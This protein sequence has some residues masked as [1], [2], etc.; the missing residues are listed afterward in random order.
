ML[1]NI[2]SKLSAQVGLTIIGTLLNAFSGGLA[3]SF[4]IPFFNLFSGESNHGGGYERIAQS[5]P[6]RNT[7]PIILNFKVGKQTSKQIVID[8]MTEA[9][10]SREIV[11]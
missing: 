5:Q 10:K 8:G 11:F 2:I 4:G 3:E 7:Q 9:V 1:S 6:A